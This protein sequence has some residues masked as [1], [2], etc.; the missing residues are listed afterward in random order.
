MQNLVNR[1]RTLT[2]AGTAE[3]TA[4]TVVYWTD[5]HIQDILDSN[6]TFAVDSPLA[7]LPQTIS[8][9]SAVYLVAQA[10]YRDTEEIASGTARWI[11][12]NGAG[13][14][15]GTANY[16]PD[17]RAG[18][19]V[20]SADQSGSAYYLTCCSYDVYAA[21]ADLWLERLAYFNEWYDFRA[22]NQQFTRSQ[23]WEHAQKMEQAMRGKAGQNLVIVAGGDLRASEFVRVDLR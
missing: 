3:Y 20:F 15:V 23:A 17:Y 21:A 14:E 1:V 10:E 2:R 18:R 8:G 9:G 19:V 11:I 12:R 16:T 5:N 6:V 13:A 22:D 7:W 4:G